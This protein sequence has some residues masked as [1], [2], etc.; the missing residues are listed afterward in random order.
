VAASKCVNWLFGRGLSIGCNLP[1]S[2]PAEWSHLAREERISR[3]KVVLRQEMD[4]ATVDCK[5]IRCLLELL[6]KHTV[7]GWRHRF[8]TTNWDYLLQR[9]ILALPMK[10]QPPWLA[11]SHVFH[12]NG[13]VE[14]LPDN[15]NRSL[16]LLEEDSG[17]QRT[18]TPEADI[19]YN[20]MTWDRTFVLVGMSFECETDR[21]LLLALGRVEDDLPIGE[22]SWVVVNPDRNV[23]GLS[24]QRL[25]KA[26]PRASVKPVC[27]T[28]SEW[29]Q[30]GPQELRQW[31]I[32]AF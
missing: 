26:L 23:L 30:N 6:A 31:G 21:F 2:V 3:I 17:T 11:N 14:D 1:W 27:A 16:F 7:A 22:S 8:I 20:Q 12:L 24:C 29:V 19:V 9:E 18:A 4:A 13:T 5:V 10:V 15:S 28:L 32:L 25:Q